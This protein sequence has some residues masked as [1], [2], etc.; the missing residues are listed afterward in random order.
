MVYPARLADSRRLKP[1][2]S[3]QKYDAKQLNSGSCEEAQD[4]K[5]R[6]E[7][8]DVLTE[9]LRQWLQD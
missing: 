1:L 5:E 4:S 7:V 9:C 6:F 2:S 8:R 3:P